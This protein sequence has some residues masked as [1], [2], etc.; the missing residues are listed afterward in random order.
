MSVCHV[1]GERP[2]RRLY[3]SARLRHHQIHVLIDR[4][5]RRTPRMSWPIQV[6]SR[7]TRGR[8]GSPACGCA[9]LD[10]AE[11]VPSDGPAVAAAKQSSATR[12]WVVRNLTWLA[13]SKML[14]RSQ[15]A[16]SHPYKHTRT[17]YL[18]KHLRKTES[19]FLKI[20]EVILTLVNI[21]ERLGRY[22]LRLM[23]SPR[24]FRSHTPY[25]YAHLWKTGSAFLEI[26]EV[27]TTSIS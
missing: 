6:T 11:L 5:Q 16:Y 20:D 23:K 21:S 17:L 8:W 10:D 2:R 14:Y 19:V 4:Q 3:G 26:D 22:F 18:F 12:R 25:P 7:G 27:T 13:I 9:G 24:I 1:A 15:R